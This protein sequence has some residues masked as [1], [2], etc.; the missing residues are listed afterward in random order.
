VFPLRYVDEIK[1][2]ATPGQYH[3]SRLVVAAHHDVDKTSV[4]TQSPTIQRISQRLVLVLKLM[5]GDEVE[6]CLRDIV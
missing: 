2:K 4:L 1:Y 6:I 5:Y 3:N